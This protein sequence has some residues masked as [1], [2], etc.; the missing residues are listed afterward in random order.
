MKRLFKHTLVMVGIAAAFAAS[1]L[2]ANN[3]TDNA[4]NYITW[5]SGDNLGSG[6]GAWTLAT[7]NTDG[8]HFAGFFLGDSTTLGGGANINTSGKAFGMFAN[9]AQFGS[10]P[11]ADA[12]RDF[13]SP[14]TVGQTFSL[15]LAVNFR[16]GNKGIDLRDG[17]TTI[18]NFNIGA[19]DYVVNSAA[20]GNGSIG[21]TY[22]ANTVFH[23]EFTQLTLGGG[24]WT[25]T[26][27]GGV[28]DLDSGTYSGLAS[29]FK[30]YI[31]GTDAGN[32][33]NNLFANNLQ[34]IP[35]P[36]TFGLVG[37]GLLGAWFLR[38]RKA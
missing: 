33:A 32:D 14:L 7:G 37:I 3:G 12:T 5:G 28:S 25:I 16:N 26:R 35:E 13:S 1:A 22:S 9:P 8:S 20:T 17:V 4:G 38:R 34:I 23:L 36:S 11:F 30:L 31:S 15:D 2:A 10:D 21:N 6:F 18:F 19:D 24:S 29:G 27:S